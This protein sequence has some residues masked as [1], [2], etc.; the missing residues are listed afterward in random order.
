MWLIVGRKL[1]LRY[2]GAS[3][4]AAL[5]N[6]NEETQDAIKQVL[7]MGWNWF[8]T[9]TI[10]TGKTIESTDKD[11]NVTETEEILAPYAVLAK[12]LSRYAV[13]QLRAYK[14]GAGAKAAEYER[15]MIAELQ[16]PG[17]PLAAALQTALPGMFARAAKD[18][19]ILPIILASPIGQAIIDKLMSKVT[20]KGSTVSVASGGTQ[21]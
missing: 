2:A 7:T 20:A 15:Q 4:V 21:W 5:R 6:P 13:Q 18:G 14:G 16:N 9:P 12:E 1:L 3:V 8:L 11:G 10:K 17:N 19:S